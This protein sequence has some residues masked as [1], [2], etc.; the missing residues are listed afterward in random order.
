MD[1]FDAHIDRIHYLVERSNELLKWG[2]EDEARILM[3]QAI[4]ISMEI[5]GNTL[6]LASA[7]YS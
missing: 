1:R 5:K 4:A 3:E 2:M 7:V 6:P